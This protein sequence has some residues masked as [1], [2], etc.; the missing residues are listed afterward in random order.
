MACVMGTAVSLSQVC[1][2]STSPLVS[3]QHL[4]RLSASI[5]VGGNLCAVRSTS[6]LSRRAAG[7]CISITAGN[8]LEGETICTCLSLW[9]VRAA[10]CGV[11]T[12]APPRCLLVDVISVYFAFNFQ[13]H[14]WREASEK[15]SPQEMPIIVKQE[16]K[17]LIS[18]GLRGNP[19]GGSLFPGFPSF[20]MI[21]I[22]THLWLK[23]I[24][25][26]HRGFEASVNVK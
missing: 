16:L 20:S 23:V 5:K 22:T 8:L 9:C 10:V 14:H 1:M 2:T 7:I 17:R 25:W 4:L 12:H 3:L 26:G 24:C 18:S 21:L 11:N 13:K 19:S 15:S 6:H